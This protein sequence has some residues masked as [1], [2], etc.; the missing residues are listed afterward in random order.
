VEASYAGSNAQARSHVFVTLDGQ[1]VDEK[2]IVLSP[3]DQI[4][5]PLT[6]RAPEEGTFEV[7]VNG[8]T[9]YITISGSAPSS[10]L[11]Q[12]VTLATQDAMGT[13]AIASPTLWSRWRT[14]VYAG[15]ALVLLILSVPVIGAFRRR[16][17]RCR[18]DL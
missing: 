8:L 11:F 12:A 18:Y 3:G 17:L 2:E 6:V 7:A 1:I 5:V 13:S 4:S 14:A 10:V 15:G 9:D 16:L